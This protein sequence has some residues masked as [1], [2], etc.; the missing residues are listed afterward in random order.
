M[1]GHTLGAAGGI[2]AAVCAKV[3][4]T[5]EVPLQPQKWRLG[6]GLGFGFGFG[7]GV[8]WWRHSWRHMPPAVRGYGSGLLHALQRR[9]YS[10]APLAQWQHMAQGQ[11]MGLLSEP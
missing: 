11:H 10:Y 1:T 2:E 5:G 4:Q 7:L 6:F 9:T 3:L 8:P